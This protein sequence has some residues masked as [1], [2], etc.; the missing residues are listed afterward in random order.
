MSRPLITTW[1]MLIPGEA[2]DINGQTWTVAAR[3]GDSIT[4][5]RDRDGFE[6]TGAPPRDKQ[7]NV[8]SQR[9][10][11]GAI[12]AIESIGGKIK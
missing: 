1:S 12:A 10:L 2:L 11:A 5:R 8:V 9:S 3:E 4:M 7:V 6:Q